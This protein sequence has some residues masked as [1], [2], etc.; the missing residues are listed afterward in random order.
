MYKLFAV[1]VL[2]ALMVAPAAR[3]QESG[4]PICTETEILVFS[5]SLIN[6]LEMLD[7]ASTQTLDDLV[8]HAVEQVESRENDFLLMPLCAEA[9]DLQRRSFAE[10]SDF[11]GGIALRLARVPDVAN[12]YALRLPDSEGRLQAFQAVLRRADNSQ[13]PGPEDRQ[14]PACTVAQAL[15]LDALTESFDVKYRRVNKLEGDYKWLEVVDQLLQWREQILGEIPECLEAIE[16][17]F[18]LS[19]AASDAAALAALQHAGVADER[20]PYI[21]PVIAVR[22]KMNAWKDE[23][24]LTREENQG[25]SLLILGRPSQLAACSAAEIKDALDERLG[26]YLD[27]AEL[28]HSVT[29]VDD[30]AD[31]GRAH[32][33]LRHGMLSQ[34]PRCAEVFEFEWLAKQLLGDLA[35]G[36][37]YK[38][39]GYATSDNPFAAAVEVHTS[40]LGNWMVDMSALLADDERGEGPAPAEREV[41]VCS[42]PE[43]IYVMSYLMPDLSRFVNEGLTLDTVE[44]RDA[45]IDQSFALRDRLWAELPRCQEALKVGMD[46]RQIAGDWMPMMTMDTAGAQLRDIPYLFEV[47]ERMELI[48]QYSDELK[49]GA[50]AAQG[51]VSVGQSYTVTA[52]PYANIRA[53]AST[54]CAIVGTAQRGEAIEV[55]DDSSEWYEI[56]LDDGGTGFIAGFLARKTQP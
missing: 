4:F 5:S 34:L 3:G 56:R 45:L 27:V 24:E 36:A 35:A 22:Q 11:V 43:V 30:L 2:I 46:M 50:E 9:I 23:L 26:E 29:S 21:D 12:P 18:M 25:A 51:P 54:D 38:I 20:N 7:R 16:V 31:F 28:I 49:G 17:G 32:M 19:K 52:N 47:R 10:Q 37:A 42:A 8:K 55:I 48:S 1:A 6:R 53:C 44:R 14:A 13:A 40:K 15:K 41:E 33:E 39:M